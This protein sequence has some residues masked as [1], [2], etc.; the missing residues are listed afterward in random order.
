MPRQMLA[1]RAHAKEKY[2]ISNS[3]LGKERWQTPTFPHAYQPKRK[4]LI[5]AA[6]FG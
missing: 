4:R 5:P 2:K 3:K 6:N 1:E